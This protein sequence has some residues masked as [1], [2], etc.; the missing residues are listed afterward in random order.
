[1]EGLNN[2][3]SSFDS[4]KGLTMGMRPRMW[5]LVKKNYGKLWT[6]TYTYFQKLV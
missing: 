6:S 5:R 1:M 2:K 4:M 3:C